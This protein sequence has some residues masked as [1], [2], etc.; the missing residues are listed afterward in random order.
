MLSLWSYF[1]HEDCKTILLAVTVLN[2]LISTHIQTNENV[3]E[4]P[5]LLHNKDK[6]CGVKHIQV[7]TQKMSSFESDLPT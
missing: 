1:S 4:Q 6:A 5:I 2:A 7:V 3:H